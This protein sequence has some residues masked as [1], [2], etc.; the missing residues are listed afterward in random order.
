[1]NRLLVLALFLVAVL[2]MLVDIAPISISAGGLFLSLI[3]VL[4]LGFGVTYFALGDEYRYRNPTFDREI[5]RV[6]ELVGGLLLSLAF[7]FHPAHP[8]SHGSGSFF[9]RSLVADHGVFFAYFF[10]PSLGTALIWGGLVW[11]RRCEQT[12]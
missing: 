2:A 7:L 1:M 11:A 8:F 9:F 6:T 5:N 3:S 10:N 4:P 12:K